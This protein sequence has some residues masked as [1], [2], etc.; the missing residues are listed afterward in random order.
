MPQ[1][2]KGNIAQAIKDVANRAALKSAAKEW[3]VP[4]NTLRNRIKGSEGYSIAAESQQR[5]L[6]V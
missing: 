4:P 6:R 3:G 5:L 1:Y 2:T